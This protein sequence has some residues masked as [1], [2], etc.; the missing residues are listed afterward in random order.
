MSQTSAPE[1]PT[2][3]LRPESDGFLPPS[4]SEHVDAGIPQRVEPRTVPSGKVLARP[5]H[6]GHTV[7]GEPLLRLAEGDRGARTQREID[8]RGID[9]ALERARRG[10]HASAQQQDSEPSVA[11]VPPPTP[12]RPQSGWYWAAGAMVPLVVVGAV[13][14]LRR[15]AQPAAAVPAHGAIVGEHHAMPD[16]PAS[17]STSPSEASLNG[18]PPTTESVEPPETTASPPSEAPTTAR[19][20]ALPEPDLEGKPRTNAATS[21]RRSTVAPQ[22]NAQPSD[23][24][25]VREATSA[26]ATS[27]GARTET[28]PHASTS[29]AAT[30]ARPILIHVKSK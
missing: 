30:D 29:T 20:E 2:A 22:A 10:R 1:R 8:R 27:D 7:D 4:R 5:E 23:A 11:E 13:V 18:A 16:G 28:P 6:A 15:G 9:E 14:G 25:N 19:P 17:L 24:T 21:S 3:S 26:R 12:M